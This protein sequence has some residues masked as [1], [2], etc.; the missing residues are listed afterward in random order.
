MA[1]LVEG[2]IDSV[3][4]VQEIIEIKLEPSLGPQANQASEEIVVA[5]LAVGG[6]AHYLSLISIVVLA[7]ELAN[8]RIQNAERMRE[9]SSVK[10][11]DLILP[12]QGGQSRRKVAES[13]RA[14]NSGP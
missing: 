11:F 9:Q 13:V 5:G 10:H 1:L 3:A 2:V 8:H 12:S 14:Q 4:M 7:N 6:Q